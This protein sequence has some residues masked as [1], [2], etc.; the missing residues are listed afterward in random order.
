M[1]ILDGK[2]LSSEI[3]AEIKS[4]VA[5][6]SFQPIFCDVLVGGD[7]ASLQYVQ[8]KAMA[9]ESVGIKFHSANFPESITTEELIKEIQTLN[10]TQNMCGIII[11]L[12]LPAH[13]DKKAILDSINP[14]LDVDCLGQEMSEKFYSDQP[15]LVYPTALAC[16]RILDS[17]NLDDNPSTSLDKAQNKS[18]RTR[19]IVMLGQGTLVGRPVTHILEY[20]GYKVFK[21]KRDTEN[22]PEI[23]KNADIIISAIGV[24]KFIKGDMIKSGAII[25]DAG[26]SEEDGGV[27]GDVDFNS[28]KDI[29]S[30]VSPTPGGVGP[31]TV[32]M[33]LN[34]VLQV[35]K[36][37]R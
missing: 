11:Q 21:I 37:L 27:V 8:M 35:A 5:T 13:I 25:I 6:L 30:M 34:N 12:P 32:A 15:E 7:P 10:K 4:V 9:A 18:L 2:K 24:G 16:M 23:L 1:T 17:M 31:V 33:L 3:L 36:N 26:T 20:R 14:K 19:N 29:A 28:V 22:I